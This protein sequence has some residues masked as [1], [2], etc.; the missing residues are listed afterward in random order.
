MRFKEFKQYRL[1]GYN[2]SSSGDY[3]I[4]ICVKNKLESFGR[5]INSKMVLSEIGIVAENLWKKLPSKFSRINLDKFQIMPDHIHGIIHLRDSEFDRRNTPQNLNQD[6]R[7]VPTQANDQSK[8]NN[9]HPLIKNS[10]PSMINHY[11]GSV[12]LWCK[13]NGYPDFKWQARYY[14]RIIRNKQELFTIRKYIESNPQK[15][16]E[17]LGI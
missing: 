9:L 5:I 1:P 3:F 10:I 7:R 14:D 16:I 11:K 6:Q 2:Y 4:T 12:T 17:K 15:L 8:S 13:N